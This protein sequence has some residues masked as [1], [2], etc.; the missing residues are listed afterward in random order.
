VLATGLLGF[1]LLEGGTL[2]GLHPPR[3]PAASRL[4]GREV[5]P[6]T[7]GPARPRRP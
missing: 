1:R 5:Q 4:R 6:S 7:G 2:L 3:V